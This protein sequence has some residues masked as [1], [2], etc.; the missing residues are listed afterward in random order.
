MNP[1]QNNGRIQLL[2]ND[3]Y[4]IY[5]LFAE[6]THQYKNFSEEAIKNIHVEN[7]LSELFF[8][9]KNA[10]ILQDAIRNIIYEKSKYL[11]D[12]QSD[13]ELRIIMRSIY[14]EHGRHKLYGTIEEVKRLNGLVLQFC[15]PRILQEIRLYITYK[16]DVDRIPNPIDRGQFA[17]S[18]G[19]RQLIQKEF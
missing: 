19:S 6:P 7:E 3:N 17:S 1:N 9:P 8:S 5:N 2:N 10:D 16:N 18:K 4:N 12:R 15:V 14:L 11:I 13:T